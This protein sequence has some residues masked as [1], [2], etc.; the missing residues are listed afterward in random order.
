LLF[1]GT[2]DLLVPY[3]RDRVGCAQA[4][5]FQNRCELVT[6]VNGEHDIGFVRFAYITDR[7]ARFFAPIA[8]GKSMSP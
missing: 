2:H 5:H 6:I 4:H 3:E 7:T 8:N 1:H